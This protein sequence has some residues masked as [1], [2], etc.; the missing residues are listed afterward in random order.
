MDDR[1]A[2]IGFGV[3]FRILLIGFL[4][5]A[6]CPALFVVFDGLRDVFDYK[7]IPEMGFRKDREI[8]RGRT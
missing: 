1:H 6:A 3:L 8:K 2:P 4:N 5:A 7:P